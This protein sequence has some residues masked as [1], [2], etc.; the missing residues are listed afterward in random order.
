MRL[1]PLQ[2]ESRAR[3]LPDLAPQGF[4]PDSINVE[5]FLNLR[6]DGTDVAIMTKL[7]T[8]AA[9][10]PDEARAS[11]H[12]AG[13]SC[14]YRGAFEASYRREFGFVL[15]RGIWVDDVRVR[16]TGRS[17]PLMERAT[18]AQDP[19]ECTHLPAGQA[20]ASHTARMHGRSATRFEEAM[21]APTLCGGLE[22]AGGPCGFA[23]CAGSPCLP[24]ESFVGCI[25]RAMLTT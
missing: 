23:A 17:R 1:R 21:A 24:S 5:R 14:S 4:T 2:L 9:A 20:A 6:Y 25:R 13:A 18:I 3:C 8:T 16:A 15:G 12:A 22:H 7:P 10:A 11:S 19:G